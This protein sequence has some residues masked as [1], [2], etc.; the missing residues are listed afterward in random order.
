MLNIKQNK[1]VV[2]SKI[3]NMKRLGF[4]LLIAF[5][6]V[7]AHKTEAQ[8]IANKLKS[9]STGIDSTVLVND[10]GE[11]TKKETVNR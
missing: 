1:N 5:F 6:V 3:I 2:I 9:V 8:T 7:F 4:S 11:P 10:I